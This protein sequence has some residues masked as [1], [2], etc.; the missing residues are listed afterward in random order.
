LLRAAAEPNAIDP[1]AD[2][3]LTKCAKALLPERSRALLTEDDSR[4]GSSARRLSHARL[5]VA[6]AA[7]R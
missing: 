6:E 5:E 4:V 7:G 1:C 3:L 2:R